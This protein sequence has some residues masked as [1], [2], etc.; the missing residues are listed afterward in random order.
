MNIPRRLYLFVSTLTVVVY[1][2]LCAMPARAQI[3]KNDSVGLQGTI[4]ADPPTQGASISL[5]TNGQN[6]T[7]TPITVTGICPKDLLVKVY[8][9]NIFGGSAYC[10]SQGN[11]SLQVDLFPGTN[12]LVAR[13]F[14]SLDQAGPD[15]ATVTVRF[16]DNLTI[17]ATARLVLT[18]NYANKG[19]NPGEDIKWPFIISGGTAPYALAV[20]WGDQVSSPYT[21]IVAGE[22]VASHKY[23]KAGINT[24][25]VRATDSKGATAYLQVVAVV[26]GQ[27]ENASSNTTENHTLTKYV[28]WP[29]LVLI[30]VV[31]LTF[32]LATR[33]ENRRLRHMLARGEQPFE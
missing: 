14:D 22:V 10:T 8:K 9:N 7:S 16:N 29:V 1:G 15:S 31:L 27:A 11:F 17:P 13:V 26:N 30:P 3:T 2:M 18:S 25:V 24:V 32:W 21:S 19:T 20:D 4:S 6:V 5:P 23:E 12:D 33:H 28:V